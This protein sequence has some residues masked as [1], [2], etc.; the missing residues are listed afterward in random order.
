MSPAQLHIPVGLAR[1]DGHHF[2]DREETY[3]LNL[4]LVGLANPGTLTAIRFLPSWLRDILVWYIEHNWYG[5]WDT[6]FEAITNDECAELRFTIW[7]SI[8][9]STYRTGC[10]GEY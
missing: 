3:H 4:I 6:T 2:L 8:D 7:G 5:L 9:S 1:F 10:T